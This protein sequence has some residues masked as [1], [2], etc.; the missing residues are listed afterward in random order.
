MDTTLHNNPRTIPAEKQ[1]KME[2]ILGKMSRV[3][4]GIDPYQDVVFSTAEMV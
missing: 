3:R 1:K 4:S 2:H